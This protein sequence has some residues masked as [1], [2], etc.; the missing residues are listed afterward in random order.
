[1][2]CT[3]KKRQSELGGVHRLELQ[4]ECCASKAE[5]DAMWPLGQQQEHAPCIKQHTVQAWSP[6]A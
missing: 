5:D 3:N 4:A 6:P 2:I 1:M